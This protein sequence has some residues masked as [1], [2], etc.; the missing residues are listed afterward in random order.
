MHGRGYG[1]EI[2]PA[3]LLAQLCQKHH[4]EQQITELVADPAGLRAADGVGQFVGFFDGVRRDAREG[5]QLVPGAALLWIAEPHHQGQQCFQSLRGLAH[6]S[7]RSAALSACRMIAVAPQTLRPSKF[8][9]FRMISTPWR[10]RR[11][12]WKLSGW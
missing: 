1:G 3:A 4:L 11:V 10:T 9:S 8:R 2:K 5:L 12:G 7:F 6:A